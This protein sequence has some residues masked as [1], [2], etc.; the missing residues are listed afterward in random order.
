MDRVMTLGVVTDVAN[1]F[2]GFVA[3]MYTPSP[4]GRLPILVAL[5]KEHRYL[6]LSLLGVLLLIVVGALRS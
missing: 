6:Y 4:D 3:D 5:Q 2:V 1:A